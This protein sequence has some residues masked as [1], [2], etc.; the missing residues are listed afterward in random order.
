MA[1]VTMTHETFEHLL[2]ERPNMT[3]AELGGA[4]VVKDSPAVTGA[5]MVFVLPLPPSANRYWRMVNGH[6]TVSAEAKAYK[7]SAGWAAKVAGIDVLEG[8]VA[9]TL[10]VY[11]A[12]KSGDL[13]NRIKVILDS[14]KG[15]AWGD[16][17]QVTELHAYRYDDK[18]N[19]RVEVEITGI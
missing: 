6:M 15:V 7:T 14:L 19:P 3:L 17:S 13:D 18:T 16:D 12:Q 8:A 4:I 2:Q 11:R 9:V 10:R 5:T 1:I